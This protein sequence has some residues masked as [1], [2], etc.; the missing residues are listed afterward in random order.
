[1]EVPPG[2]YRLTLYRIDHEALEQEGRTWHGA[3]EVVVLTPGGTAAEAAEDLLPF[4]PRRDRSWIGRYAIRGRRVDAL[5]WFSDFWDT[6]VVNLDSTAV[7]E[8][9]LAPGSILR[10]EVPSVPITLTSVIGSSWDDAR[11]TA[12]S[13]WAA[14]SIGACPR[15]SP[16]CWC[17]RAASSSSS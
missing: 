9:G 16:P 10:V 1:V 12:H 6:F 17:G 8:L 5:V 3:Q 14:A 7:A 13:R 2:D 15:G 11:R 4:A